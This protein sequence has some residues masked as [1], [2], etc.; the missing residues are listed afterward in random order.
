MDGYTKAFAAAMQKDGSIV[1]R[2][3]NKIRKIIKNP[4][5]LFQFSLYFISFA[6]VLIIAYMNQKVKLT[7]HSYKLIG[8]F[9]CA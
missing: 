6:I 8:I 1:R 2:F 9:N 7:L 5:T 3:T 4:V